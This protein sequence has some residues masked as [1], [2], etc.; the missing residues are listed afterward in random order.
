MYLHLSYAE[1]NM[2]NG[3]NH[4]SSKLMQ[5]FLMPSGKKSLMWDHTVH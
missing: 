3:S 1:Q 2:K 4:K 5:R